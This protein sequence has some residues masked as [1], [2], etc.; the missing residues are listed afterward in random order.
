MIQFNLLLANV[1]LIVWFIL[2]LNNVDDIL[3]TTYSNASSWIR[4]LYYFD[5][6]FR[7]ICS[8]G[9]NWQYVSIGS[10]HDDVIK[11]KHFPRYWPFVRGIHRSPVNS[12]HKGQWR[13]ALMFSLICAWINGW[14]NTGE[15][16]DSGRHHAHYDV[17]VMWW[18]CSKN[19]ISQC[20]E[21]WLRSSPS[22]T[23]LTHDDVI[24]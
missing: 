16:G 6:H 1:T 12:E 22:P 21:H 2:G 24:K 17:I 18:L 15:A 8:Y 13:G 14:V 20:Q 7:E 9:S 3:Q 4:F 23:E 11:W 19:A 5:L 10:R